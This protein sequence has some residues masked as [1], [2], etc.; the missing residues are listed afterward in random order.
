MNILTVIPIFRNKFQNP[1]LFFTRENFSIGS[2]ILVPYSKTINPKKLKEKPALI[3][4][5][6][7]LKE[8]K[9]FLRKNDIQIN[10]TT[11][12]IEFNFF[13][14]KIINDIKRKSSKIQKS[15]EF[16]LEKLFTKKVKEELNKITKLSKKS[17]IKDY[18]K[19]ITPDFTSQKLKPFLIKKK[20]IISK[21][22][23]IQSI[24]SLLSKNRVSKN[25]L[26]S[27]KH[28]LVDEIRKYFGET[29]KKGKGSF[30]FY[31]G[32]FNRLPKSII[33]QYWA[34]VKE[35]RKSIKSQ[36]KIFWW[37]IGNFLKEKN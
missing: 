14:E 4:E 25:K 31:L 6:S 18:T 10:K 20:T 9:Q 11:N 3:I 24:N 36:Q 28:Y 12:S 22:K 1:T 17:V 26:H 29:A 19:K 27:E 34:D 16:S 2:I 33:Y 7:N 32:F 15:L 21:K 23:G 37:K 8:T 5:K 13:S 30:G 35:S